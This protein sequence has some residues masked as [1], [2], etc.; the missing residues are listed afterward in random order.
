[1]GLHLVADLMISL[2]LFC[3]LPTEVFVFG[4]RNALADH[5]QWYILNKTS[6]ILRSRL[7]KASLRWIGL[8][9]TLSQSLC[10]VMSGFS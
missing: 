2:L 3:T 8:L 7:L 4:S 1:M 9:L 5:S 10:F 6:D